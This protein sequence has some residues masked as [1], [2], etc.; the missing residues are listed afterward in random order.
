MKRHISI[1]LAIVLLSSVF[2]LFGVNV[3]ADYPEIASMNG[4]ENLCLTYT[5]N[6][7][8]GDNGRHTVDDLMPYVAYY[9]KNRQIKDFFFDSYLFLPCQK[10][11]PSG[12]SLHYWYS[13]PTKAIDWTSY[14]EDTFY[15]D[16]NVEALDTAFGRAKEA[17]NAPDKKAGVFFTIL[18]PGTPSGA[19]FGSLGGKE[20][21]LSKMEDRKAAIKWIIDEQIRLYTEGNYENLDLI[22]FYWME[23]YINATSDKELF[24]YASDYLHSLGLKFLWIPHY[25]ANGYA[26]WADYGFDVACRQPNRYWDGSLSKSR[27]ETCVDTC[28]SYGMSVEIELDQNA[29]SNSDYYNRYLDYLEVCMQK[30][31]MDTIKMYYQGGKEGVYY[32]AS[33]STHARA[34]S[35]Y[36]LTYKYAKG[37]LTQADIDEMRDES[38]IVVPPFTLPEDVD[39]ISIGKKYVATQ[40]YS[41]GSGAKYQDNDGKELTDGIIGTSD[42]GTDWHAFHVSRLDSDKRMS[43]TI[44]LGEVRDDLTDF[45]IQFNHIQLHGIGDPAN[46]IKVYISED[47]TNY[48]PIGE[49]E[50]KYYEYTVYVHHKTIPLTARYVKFSFINS[51]GTNFV[52]CGEAAVGVSED[53]EGGYVPDDE[54]TNA[55]LGD[56]DNDGDVDA[57]DYVLVKRSVLKTY[58]LSKEQTECADVDADGDVDATDYVLVKRIVLGTYKAK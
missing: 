16:R 14:V 42:M 18:Y 17:L 35:V 57:A 31:A 56:V 4:Y 58:T 36:D 45:L 29:L 8:R 52:F 46:D 40:P 48:R 55:K 39:W 38:N 10:A 20:L 22:G 32:A 30:G 19:D 41:D 23:E 26:E 47:G 50:L 15:D 25:R 2:S 13:T 7:D 49:P 1:L 24:K 9:D 43:V 28:E 33:R 37:T 5:W 12:G 54:T 27:V 51:T 6:P 44:D 21:D 3:S 53:W 11:G 34:R